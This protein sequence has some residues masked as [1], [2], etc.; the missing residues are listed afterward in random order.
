MNKYSIFIECIYRSIFLHTKR[1]FIAKDWLLWYVYGQKGKNNI[2]FK[3][4]QTHVSLS[5]T[6]ILFLFSLPL[7]N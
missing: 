5:Q 4:D 7:H 1:V 2:P 6:F 3:K